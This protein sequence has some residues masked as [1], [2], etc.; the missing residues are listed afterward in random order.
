[1]TE[2]PAS[3]KFYTILVAEDHEFTRT[4]LAYAFQKST[5][6][7]IVGEAENGV[8]AVRLAKELKPDFVLM[9]IG[10]P[11]MDGIAATQE[12]KRNLPDVKVVIL[13]SRQFSEEIFAS[14]A[15][16]ADA[17]CMK[18]ISTERLLTVMSSVVSGALWLDP[19]IARIV[20]NALPSCTGAGGGEAL[21][22]GSSRSS[23]AYH[24]NL[25]ERELEVLTQIA[26]GKTNKEIAATLELSIHTVKAHVRN[27]IQK[28]AVDDRTQAAVKAL[29]DGLV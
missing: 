11:L 19:S 15:S 4:G 26:L 16:G 13:T 22:G 9:D 12:I 21:A 23:G 6:F 5:E 20:V 24:A 29:Q 2:N 18:D 7:K 1:M 10:M 25:T 17:Y 3:N 27:L 14:L 8:D 28:L